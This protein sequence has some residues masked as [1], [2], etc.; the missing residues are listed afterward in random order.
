MMVW[1]YA[2]GFAMAAKPAEN[3]SAASA[4]G[5]GAVGEKKATL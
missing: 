5:S 3:M 2:N 4:S 1:H